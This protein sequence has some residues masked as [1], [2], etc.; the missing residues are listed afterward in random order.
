[1]FTDCFPEGAAQPDYNSVDASLWYVIAVQDY[2]AAAKAAGRKIGARDRRRLEAA[3][4]AILRGYSGGTRFGIRADADGL[5]WAGQPGVQLTWMDAKVGD[6][7]VTPR[8]GKPVEVQALW[9]NAL[10]AGANLDPDWAVRAERATESFGRRFWNEQAGCLFD[11]VD[12]DFEPGE[13]AIRRCV[14][15]RSSRSVGYPRPSWTGRGRPACSR[16]WSGAC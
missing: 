10:R 4:G 14:P 9:I 13:E 1:M 11:V 16:W 15:T 7:V 12:A 2:V 6:W 5:L 8:I 3:V